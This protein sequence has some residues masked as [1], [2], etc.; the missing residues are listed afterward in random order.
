MSPPA[1]TAKA[2]AVIG[3]LKKLK[4]GA[5]SSSRLVPYLKPSARRP[6]SMWKARIMKNR[7][8]FIKMLP[9]ASDRIGVIRGHTKSFLPFAVAVSR[10]P[11]G[12]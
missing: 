2:F 6:A 10:M 4:D 1:A 7:D 9:I 11:S 8:P 3:I 5:S 12:C